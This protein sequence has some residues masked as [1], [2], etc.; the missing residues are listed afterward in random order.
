MAVVRDPE[1]PQP[2]FD[3]E[4]LLKLLEE[5]DRRTGFVFDPTVTPEKVR[6]LM[7]ACGVRPE[8]NIFSR[9]IIRAKYPDEE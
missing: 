9:D 3:K 6:D 1:V 7:R 8:D 2:G 4:A 5:Q